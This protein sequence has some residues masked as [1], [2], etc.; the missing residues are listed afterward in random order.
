[1]SGPITKAVTQAIALDAG[2]HWTIYWNRGENKRRATD[3]RIPRPSQVPALTQDGKEFIDAVLRLRLS[4]SHVAAT[5]EAD[6]P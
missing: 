1:M 2:D 5:R 6:L 4:K 3:R